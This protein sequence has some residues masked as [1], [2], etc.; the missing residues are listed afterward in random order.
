MSTEQGSKDNS[1]KGS[2]NVNVTLYTAFC[3]PDVQ[4]VV[5]HSEPSNEQ[6]NVPRPG[7]QIKLNDPRI[8]AWSSR[9]KLL[10]IHANSYLS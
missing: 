9:L 1:N 10:V 4:C 7:D 5:P 6:G 8:S 2:V 3:E